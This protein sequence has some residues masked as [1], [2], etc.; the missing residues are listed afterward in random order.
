MAKKTRW[1]YGCLFFI[2]LLGS[3]VYY[4]D[5]YRASFW[6]EPEY[7]PFS[8]LTKDTHQQLLLFFKGLDPG[9]QEHLYKVANLQRNY[10]EKIIGHQIDRPGE[11]RDQV[12]WNYRNVVSY[13]VVGHPDYHRV[14]VW[15]AKELKISEEK[16]K[17]LSS[18]YLEEAILEAVL[19]RAETLLTEEE[20]ERLLKNAV[21]GTSIAWTSISMASLLGLVEAGAW[22]SGPYGWALGGLVSILNITVG[23]GANLYN[24][25][26][27]IAV[28]HR[29]KK[30]LKMEFSRNA[31]IHN[32]V[33]GDIDTEF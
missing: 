33:F 28:V 3:L 20:K 13:Y 4:F 7:P 15:T 1:R 21:R 5:I 32:Q 2:L 17:V 22:V 6:S 25:L 14:L 31:R 10:V 19:R 18:Y 23:N 16:I 12:S 8:T 27:I 29:I 11:L 30:R 24:E 9:D 26:K